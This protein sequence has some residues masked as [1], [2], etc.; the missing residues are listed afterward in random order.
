ML[1]GLLISFV[2]IAVVWLVFFKFKLLKFT[3]GWGVV[4]VLFGLHLL[5]IFLIGI[6]FTAPYSKDAKVVQHTVQ[7]TP[8]LS[9]PTLVTA[10]LVEPNVPVKKGQPLFQFDRQL[11]ESKVNA[12]KAKLAAA[13]QSVLQLKASLDAATATVDESRAKKVTLQAALVASTKAVAEAKAKQVTL[14]SALDSVI[15]T[16]A[17][18][19]AERLYS[20]ETLQIAE[21]IKVSNSNAISQM[22]YDQAATEL[23]RYDAK[24][25]AAQANVERARSAYEQEALAAI[26][27]AVANEAR[28]RSEAG[29]EADAAIAVTIANQNA[30]R[31]AFESQIDGENTLVAQCKAELAEATY[32]LD[33]TTMVAPADGYII[34]LQVQPGMV[35]GIVRFG[36]IA[37]FIVDAERYVLA[38]YTQ[39]QL[40]YVKES[41]SVEVAFDLYPGEIFKGKV[42]NIW[43]GSGGGQMTPSGQLPTFVPQDPDQPQGLFAVQ[44][45]MD[46]ENES[47]FPI[48]AQ[49]AAA[50]YTGNE[51][52]GALRKIGIRGY[53]W[54]NWLYPM[55]F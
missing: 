27:V 5:L 7:L 47:Q 36:A 54:S 52:F 1:L 32:Y 29:A 41:Q 50:I 19:K 48:G 12:A 17:E 3:M 13:E 20:Q 26:D 21:S 51:G 45:V 30:A 34:N 42:E 6:R 14:K 16:L 53:S 9:E 33:N 4:S 55:D 37:T 24:V 10:V 31:L 28:L 8:R 22:K 35:A 49:G 11:Y 18:A 39:E 2:Y 40:K 15:A 46:D 23:K 25:D 44:I 38:T 43:Q